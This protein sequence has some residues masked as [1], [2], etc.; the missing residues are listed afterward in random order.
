L[1]LS[2]RGGCK[3]PSPLFVTLYSSST[4]S[5]CSQE[6]FD[7]GAAATARSARIAGALAVAT[8]RRARF[9][10]VHERRRR[11]RREQRR[12]RCPAATTKTT[13][14]T[15]TTKRKRRRKRRRRRRNASVPPFPLKKSEPVEEETTSCP[16]FSHS[17]V[18]LFF[19]LC[20]CSFFCFFFFG[21][22]VQKKIKTLNIFLLEKLVAHTLL[23]SFLH[24][25]RVHTHDSTLSRFNGIVI[26]FCLCLRAR[27][28]QQQ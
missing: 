26:V 24:F 10:I 19:F 28:Q 13:P 23:R 6:I 27:V 2:L 4:T 18:F 11:R 3:T 9:V 20:C 5:S 21:R 14:K 25:C 12:Q 15:T 1:L 8:K 22:R 17:F 7:R 16:S